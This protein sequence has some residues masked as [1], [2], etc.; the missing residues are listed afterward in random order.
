MLFHKAYPQYYRNIKAIGVDNYLDS[1]GN[2]QNQKK[3]KITKCVK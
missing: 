1:K 2:Y 3:K